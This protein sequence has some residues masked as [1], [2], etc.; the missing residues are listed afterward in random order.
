MSVQHVHRPIVPSATPAKMF[1]VQCRACGFAHDADAPTPEDAIRQIAATHEPSHAAQFVVI[2]V[3]YT[4]G[5]AGDGEKGHPLYRRN[6][7]G[8]GR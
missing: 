5:T 2:A 1:A 6:L 4:K 8:E 7:F 3:D